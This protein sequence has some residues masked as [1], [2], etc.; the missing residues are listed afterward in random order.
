MKPL[1]LIILD[2]WGV[3]PKSE[4]NAIALARTPV[5]D[6]L[7]RDYP[8]TTLDASGE[9]V[10]LPEGQMGNSEV[11]HLNIGAGRVVYQDLTR[12][13]HAIRSGDFYRNP[14]L[15]DCMRKA[16]ASSGRLHLMGLLSDGGVHSHIDHL[17]AL[18]DMAGREGVREVYIHAFLDGRDTPPQSG[19]GYLRFLQNYL[20]DKGIGKIAT[21]SGRYYAMDRDNRWERV[22]KAYN[23][24]VAGEGI[25]ASD[26][27][28]ALKKSYGEGITDEFVIPTVICDPAGK[29]VGA[30]RDGDTVFFFNFRADRARE[31]TAALTRS[32]FDKFPRKIFPA[33]AGF[34]S[35]KLYDD[36]MPLPSAFNTGKLENIFGEI[37]SK[38]G[39]KQFRIAET[40]KYA[41][42]TYFFNGG[43]E[44]PFP[45]EDRLL[46]PSPKDVATYDQKPEMSAYQLTEELERRIRSGEYGFILVNYAN[47]DMVGHTGVLE[48][49]IRAVEVI[50][51]CLGRVLSAVQEING[52]AVITS[53][54]GDI[55]QMIEYDTGKPH[56]A[57]TTNLVPF[58]ITQ[59]G[60][61]LR[62]GIFADIAP[63]LLE[64]M[65][66]EK[67]SEMTGT[68][69][70]LR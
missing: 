33:I 63:T 22:E 10:G 42:V 27:V 68:S 30:I 25:K 61:R 60:L 66:I 14:V 49:A 41:H 17:Y 31:M 47:P 39:L 67:P 59:K 56:T 11:G 45:G 20:K 38:K 8:H 64:L 2:G 36:K 58:I 35:M 50:D 69:L 54:H 15:L 53:D 18:L 4:G 21:V 40:E 32:E 28:A 55:E 16:K 43:E 7:L 44:R 13:D 46:I 6:A 19:I 37:I 1:I 29:P 23:A 24:I 62:S 57:H 12:I 51:E 34:A 5:Y 3:N 26:P 65:G 48:A 70:I 9:S 52:I